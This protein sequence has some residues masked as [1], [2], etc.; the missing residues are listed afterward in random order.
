MYNPGDPLVAFAVG[1]DH[2]S[3]PELLD[4][5]DPN[6]FVACLDI[7]HAEMDMLGCKTSA[8]QMIECLGS[9]LQAMHLHDNL[10]GGIN[11]NHAIPFSRLIQFEPIIKAFQKNNYKGDITLETCGTVDTTPNEL[12]PVLAQYMA[13]IANYFKNRIENNN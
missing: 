12:L 8:V 11:D 4:S 6:V 7:G 2:N 10:K 5:L 1:S 13:A 9:R 3:L